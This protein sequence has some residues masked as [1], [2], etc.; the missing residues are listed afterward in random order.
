MTDEVSPPAAS[1]IAAIVANALAEDRAGFDVT[2]RA[3]VAPGQRGEATI[4]YKQDGVVCGLDVAREA[5]QQ[6]SPEIEVRTSTSDG[7]WV[8]SG[9]VVATVQGP[10]GP[11]L[12]GERVGLNLL[13]RMSGIATLS[14]Q[15][16]EAAAK[17]GRA[18]VVDTRKTTPGLR[19]LERYAVRVGGA[20]NH[21]DTLQDGVLIKDNHIEAAAHRG[22]GIPALLA[23]VRAEVPHTL[24]LEIEVTTPAM[25]Y[26][27]LEGGA[28]VILLDNMTPEMMAAIVADARKEPAYARVL[29][30]ASG[31]IT[32]KT[33]AK[34]AATGVDL[35][36]CGALTHSAPALDI[37]LDVRPA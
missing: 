10:L 31:G 12:S 35:I 5:F 13:Q 20:R 19:A 4:L 15:Y 16:V 1:T 26:A 33:I 6:V 23:S 7:A 28:D 21:R 9:M 2:T 24:R 22:L 25:A 36:S 18:R 29:F 3:T 14:R 27:A 32:L 34:V 11:I 8:E 30:E 17:G 37:S